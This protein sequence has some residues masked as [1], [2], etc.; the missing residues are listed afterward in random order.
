MSLVV[1]RPMLIGGIQALFLLLFQGVSTLI[2]VVAVVSAS[3][4]LS[5]VLSYSFNVIDPE[6]KALVRARAS[7]M[8][9]RPV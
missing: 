6:D 8:I 7:F 3:W 2:G 9:G 4:M 1:L 5:G